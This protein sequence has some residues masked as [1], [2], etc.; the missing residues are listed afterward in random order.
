[1]PQPPF[2]FVWSILKIEVPHL[3]SPCRR[4]AQCCQ[5]LVG[6]NLD[7]V[8]A[9][10]KGTNLWCGVTML[11]MWNVRWVDDACCEVCWH[12]RLTSYLMPMHNKSSCVFEPNFQYTVRDM[13]PIRKHHNI[14]L[15]MFKLV[16]PGFIHWIWNET[17]CAL[18]SHVRAN[19]TKCYLPHATRI[20]AAP[21]CSHLVAFQGIV[22]YPIN[23]QIVYCFIPDPSSHGKWNHEWLIEVYWFVG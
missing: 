13:S 23:I 20:S 21:T 19:F 8:L 4:S 16:G 10:G 11:G 5:W 18:A 14:P 15:Y 17:C 2:I 6:S 7:F 22:H 3:C 1:M 12:R 9:S